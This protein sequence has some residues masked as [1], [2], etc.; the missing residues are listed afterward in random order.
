[1]Q[2]LRITLWLFCAT[3]VAFGQ[4]GVVVGT[5]QLDQIVSKT[6][7]KRVGLLVNHTAAV[8]NVHLVDL[9]TALKIDVKKIF[10]PEHGFRGT[11]DA[12]E[13]ISD[14]KDTKTGIPVISLYG[15]SR[16][17]KPEHLADIDMVVFDIQDVGVRFYTYIS[18]LHYM[19]EACAENKKKLLILD[20]PNPNGFYVDGPILKPDLKSFV[21][22]HPIPI[23]H[24]M[25][26]GELA[27]MINGEG[28][29]D[30]KLKCDLEVIKVQGYTHAMR[31]PL[32]IKPSPNLPN[33]HAIGLYPSTC[34]FEGT[35]L[36]IGRGTKHPFEVAGHPSLTTLPYQFTPIT[37][38][39]MAKN[40]PFENQLCYG[41]DMRNDSIKAQL[42][43]SY[44]INMY[45]AFGDKEK[46]FNSY[47][48]KLAGTPVLQ[49]QIRQ[50]LSEEAIRASWQPELTAFKELRKKY[51]LYP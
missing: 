16:K 44:V 7:G 40:P 14:G 18:S 51:L 39:G 11:A 3:T 10:A 12:G 50:G 35:V 46:F 20:R 26:V 36:S 21:G 9:L 49:Q 47:F 1:M 2:R 19:M 45:N 42:S 34:L 27:M 29:L 48:D 30:K 25:T 17:P 13:K 33:D 24:G 6:Q 37:I 8:G 23:V 38:E 15:N 32:A 41:I 5:A 4:A 28:W 43:L 31:Y 22:M